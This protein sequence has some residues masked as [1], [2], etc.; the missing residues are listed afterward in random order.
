MYTNE[1]ALNE[2]ST[3][4]CVELIITSIKEYKC[5]DFPIRDQ[6]SLVENEL[7]VNNYL[8]G[9]RSKVNFLTQLK[10]KNKLNTKRDAGI[11]QHQSW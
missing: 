10:C 9:M 6:N 1:G 11:S 4:N 5:M 8:H 2:L 7:C 3:N